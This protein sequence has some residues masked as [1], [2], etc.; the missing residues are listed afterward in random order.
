MF[1]KAIIE[2]RNFLNVSLTA[3]AL[4][5]LLG[6]EADDEGFVDPERIIRLYGGEYG[7]I[8]NLI[9]SGLVIGFE[10]GVIVITHW[11]QNNWLDS[12][13]I[14][15]TLHIKEKE[16]L[17]LTE[18]KKYVLSIGL[19]RG[20][21]RRGEYIPESKDSE[22]LKIN[23]NAKNMKK[24]GFNYDES[25]NSDYYEDEIDI[26]TGEKL[27]SSKKKVSK[28]TGMKKKYELLLADVEEISG[29]SIPFVNRVKQYTALKKMK[30]AGITP[31]QIRQR[32]REL[33]NDEFYK[34]NGFDLMTICSSFDKKPPEAQN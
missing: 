2:T 22:S 24:V 29:R 26:D 12:R 10:S 31:E 34:K 5:F 15:P 13:R 1:D 9:D 28:E 32:A 8:K 14:K 7:D 30:D 23:E 18:E 19:A 20:E 3:K 17:L 4:Y 33:S 6:M 11:N 21:E 27:V 16:I 25:R